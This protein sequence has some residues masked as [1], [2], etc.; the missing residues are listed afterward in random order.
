MTSNP[1]ETGFGAV[2]GTPRLWLRV[3]GLYVLALALSLYSRGDHSW[4]LFAALFFSP[5][6]SFLGYLG[7]SRT[8]AVVYNIAHSYAGPVLLTIFALVRGGPPVVGLIWAAHIGFDRALGYGLKYSS[9]FSHTHLGRIG[10]NR[11]PVGED[12]P[13]N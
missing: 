13:N 1:G 8:G 10:R 4:I 5:D 7:G 9:D 6:L 12:T 3:E 2:T 11:V